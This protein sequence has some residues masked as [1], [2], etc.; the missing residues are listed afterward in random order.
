MCEEFTSERT[1]TNVFTTENLLFEKL[2]SNT[3]N[4][5]TSKGNSFHSAK[6]TVYL[7]G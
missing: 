2:T 7:P 6:G 1:P 5:I 4:T 3:P